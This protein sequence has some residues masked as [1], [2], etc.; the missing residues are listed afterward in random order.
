MSQ[1]GCPHTNLEMI[2]IDSADSI[3]GKEQVPWMKHMLRL[4]CFVLKEDNADMHET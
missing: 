1:S 2:L 4:V 3:Q